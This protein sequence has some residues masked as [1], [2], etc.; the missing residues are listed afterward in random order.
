MNAQHTA[1]IMPEGTYLIAEQAVHSSVLEGVPRR[2]LFGLGL[3]PD[4]L[5][6]KFRF[7]KSRVDAWG[8]VATSALD[9]ACRMGANPII[10]AGQDFAY[11]WDQEYASNTIYQG[12]YFDVL[13]SGKVQ[14]PDLHGN[15]VHTTENLVAYRDYFVRRIKLATGIRFINATEGGILTQAVE[16]LPLRAALTQCA[17]SPIDVEQTLQWCH[18]PSKPAL[19]A[20]LHLSNVLKTRRTDCDC[21]NG[22]LELTAKEH[23][24]KK[25]EAEIEKKILWGRECL[26]SRL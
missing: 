20:L 1:G 2:F 18:V 13:E 3:F 9:L 19:D 24:L 14:Q 23:L 11:S 22:F 25:N 10:F 16:I 15:E 7:R 6:G 12:N 26:Q 8:S 17:Q 5:F 21:L 4:P